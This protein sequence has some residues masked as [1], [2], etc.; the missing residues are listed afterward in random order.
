[1]M[2]RH[3]IL[4]CWLVLAT[5]FVLTPAHAA[6]SDTASAEVVVLLHGLGRNNT[7][8]WRLA[9]R[10]EDAGYDV[11]RVGYQSFKA[12]PEEMIESITAQIDECCANETRRVHFVGHS[13]CGLLIRA[14]LAEQRPPELGR[15][16]LIGTPNNGTEMADHFKDHKLV[17]LLLPTATELGTD[18]DSLP[19]RLPQPDY[20]VGIIAGVVDSELSEHFFPGPNDGMVPVASTRLENMADFI[21]IDTGHSMMRYDEDVALQVIHFLERGRFH[22]G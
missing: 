6:D 16:V 2:T 15:T 5:A 20:P 3:L 7:A 13:L 17:E 19:N 10:L 9:G 18:A 11:H 21:E 12:T 8:M 4:S 22:H 14:Y 1:M